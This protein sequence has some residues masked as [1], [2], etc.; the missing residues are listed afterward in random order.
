[1]LKN[2]TSTLWKVTPRRLRLILI[3]L[4]QKKFTVSVVAVI[5]NREGKILMLDHLLR[6]GASW[7]L[8]GGFIEAGEQPEA[9]LRREIREESALELKNVELIL[10]RTISQHIEIL[11]RAESEGEPRANSREIR[12]GGW[13]AVDSL[14]EGMSQ[15]Q[16]RLIERALNRE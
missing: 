9:A 4:T 13:F 14:P 1:M 2:L 16:R 6:P 12:D 8:P 7:A 3:R 15:V 11:F 10:V 5:T